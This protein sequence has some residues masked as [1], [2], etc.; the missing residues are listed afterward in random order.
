MM[1]IRQL[2]AVVGIAAVLAGCA[3]PAAVPTPSATVAAPVPTPT[4][5]PI[6]PTVMPANRYGIDC[7]S[8]LTPS[9][10]VP[11]LGFEVLP[12][13]PDRFDREWYEALIQDR[14]LVCRWGESNGL[15]SLA[16]AATVIA[17]PYGRAALDTLIA[18]FVPAQGSSV[19][20]NVVSVPGIGDAA[21][22]SCHGSAPYLTCYWTVAV[23][24]TWLAIDFAVVGE[25]EADTVS[26][27]EYTSEV[28]PRLDSPGAALVARIA[29]SVRGAEV[30]DVPAAAMLAT[31]CQSIVDW[32]GIAAEFGLGLP[33][34]SDPFAQP[35]FS[36][37]PAVVDAMGSMAARNQSVEE[38]VVTFAAEP[39]VRETYVFVQV[40]PGGG[41][42]GD[43]ELWGGWEGESCH[44]WEGGPICELS[45]FANGRGAWVTIAGTL[46]DGLAGRVF[47]DATS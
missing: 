7:A 5:T 43:T 3:S 6:D 39:G 40:V 32:D 46:I 19:A 16:P 42:L 44:G 12:G 26:T 33:T 36:S 2:L 47:A 25:S 9:D 21:W 41:W 11:I 23:G 27:G 31:G 38:C 30:D 35:A 17:A 24:D 1:R 45:G 28:T 22:A 15:D 4:E 10:L 37:G 14:A 29:E 8:L 20:S 34:V 18:S 13:A